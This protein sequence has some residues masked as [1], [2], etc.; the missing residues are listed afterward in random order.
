MRRDG[1]ELGIAFDGDADRIGAVDETG[2]IIYGDQLLV[3]YARDAVRAARPGQ[4]VIFDV[5]CSEALPDAIDAGGGK[6]VMWKTGHSLIKE[7][8]KELQRAARG[9]DVAGTCSSPAATTATTTRSTARRGCSR[10]RRRRA[11]WRT[12][13]A[14]LPGPSPRPSSA[15]TVPTT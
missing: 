5:K 6:P 12:L 2:E 1:A 8:M 13:L 7:K 10:S 9:R 14:D 15:S 4:P 11:A 3:L